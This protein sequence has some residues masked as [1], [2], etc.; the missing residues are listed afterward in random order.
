[1]KQRWLLLVLIVGLLIAR[2]ETAQAVTGSVLVLE[3]E[4]VI[5][6]FTARYLERGLRLAEQQGAQVLVVTLDTPGGLES[7]MREMVQMLLQASVPT[8]VYVTPDGARATSAAP[9]SRCSPWRALSAW[10]PSCC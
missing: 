10:T 3:V 5:N 2:P 1:M 8:V 7:S 6:P 4:G 9:N